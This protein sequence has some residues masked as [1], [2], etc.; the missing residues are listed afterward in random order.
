[1]ASFWVVRVSGGEFAEDCK[2]GKYVALGWSELGDLSWLLDSHIET[3]Y[4]KRR[5]YDLYKKR[6]GGKHRLNRKQIENGVNQ[7]YRFVR[8]VKVGDTVLTPSVA[9]TV[10]VGKIASDYYPAHKQK[11]KCDYKQRRAVEWTKEIPRNILSQGLQNSL[12][13]HNTIFKLTGHDAELNALVQGEKLLKKWERRYPEK[14]GEIQFG[15]PLVPPIDGLIYEPT[16]EQGVVFLFS[17]L[18]KDL[19][20]IIEGIKTGF[21]DAIGMVQIGENRYARR[22]IEFEY[23]S[24]DFPKHKHD[25]AKCDMII[26]WEDDWAA[27]PSHIKVVSLQKEMERLA[28]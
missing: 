14:E 3:D 21:P 13:A 20:I 27:C 24:S 4:A 18:S 22:T 28:S 12:K 9:K 26:C 1:M 6:Y 17:K 23:R 8:E 2:A 16:N 5:L 10:L 15:R 7:V 19:G 25:P 11:D